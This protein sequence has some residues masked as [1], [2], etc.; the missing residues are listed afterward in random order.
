MMPPSTAAMPVP[1][2]ERQMLARIFAPNPFTGWHMAGV[3]GL[4]FGTII[5]VNLI[6]ATFA[7]NSWTGLVVRNS[8]VA[9]QGFDERTAR[10]RAEHAQGWQLTGDVAATG[11]H[12]ELRDADGGAIEDAAIVVSIG[13]PAHEHDDQVLT[14]HHGGEPGLYLLE[15]PF[16]AGLWAAEVSVARADGSTWTTALRLT[17]TE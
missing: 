12:F 2:L 10:R 11:L 6:M 3:I 4:F 15:T 7:A 5:T 8:Y 9:S 16:A 13:R 14:L 17:V 1:E